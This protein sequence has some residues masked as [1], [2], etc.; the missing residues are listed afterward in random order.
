MEIEHVGELERCTILVKLPVA[1]LGSISANAAPDA[2][3]TLSTNRRGSH[4][5]R[6]GL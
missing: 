3:A 2:G 6:H 1:L 5:H 4:R